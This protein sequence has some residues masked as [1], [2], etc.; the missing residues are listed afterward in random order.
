[1]LDAP[2]APRGAAQTRL[3]PTDEGIDDQLDEKK[4]K[5]QLPATTGTGTNT[6]EVQDT[7]DRP[8][9]PGGSSSTSP[10]II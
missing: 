4:I 5:G 1:M 9:D 10:I 7:I 3:R 2:A 6:M 8:N